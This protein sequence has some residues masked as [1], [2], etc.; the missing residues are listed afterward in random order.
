MSNKSEVQIFNEL[1]GKYFEFVN[2]TRTEGVRGD[3]IVFVGEDEDSYMFYHEQD[4]CEY[5]YIEQIDGDISDLCNSKII[6]AECVTEQSEN[7]DEDS[8][9]D[10]SLT[11]SF[12]KFAT[13]HGEVTVRWKGESNGYYSESVDFRKL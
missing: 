3:N 8:Y 7:T 10:R 4:C 11:W 6:K 5:V 13:I 9:D 1:I 2:V 12:Y